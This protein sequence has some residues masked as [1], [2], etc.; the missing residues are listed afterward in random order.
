MNTRNP[1]GM[2]A[3]SGRGVRAARGRRRFAG[4]AILE[5]VLA[6]TFVLLPLIFGT[7]TVGLALLEN[8]HVV[9]LNRDAGNLFARGTDFS[10][11]ANRSVLLQLANGLNISDSGGDGVIVLSVIQCTAAGQAV[12]SRRLVIG[13]PSLATSGGGSRF[14]NPKKFVG[15]DGT[16]N[17]ADPSADA[18]SFLAVFNMNPGETVYIAETYFRTNSYDLPGLLTNTGIYTK[19]FF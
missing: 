7:A 19:S 5:F 14:V 18:D 6:G 17:T 10:V 8:L 13:N 9:Q 4:S 3:G 15:T 16:V 1:I 11:P 2:R 12:C